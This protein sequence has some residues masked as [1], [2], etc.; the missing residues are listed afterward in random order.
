MTTLQLLQR[1]LVAVDAK[2]STSL[3][4][5]QKARL[6]LD[7]YDHFEQALLSCGIK[8]DPQE[9]FLD[10]GDGIVA[11]IRPVDEIPKPLLISKFVPALR[12]QLVDH[13]PDRR[14]RLRVAVHTGDVHYDGR[15]HFGFDLDLTFRLLN[16]PEFKEHLDA[17]TEPLALVV[18]EQMHESVVLHGY[19][20]IDASTFRKLV[21]VRVGGREHHGWVQVPPEAGDGS[22]V[23]IGRAARRPHLR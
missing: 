9:K 14:F 6:R 16:A 4:N 7:M 15:G 5:M 21:C 20:G 22:V 18:S 12:K 8:E 1:M 3:N 10:R 2:S 13:A 11:L 17:S 23:P 19:E